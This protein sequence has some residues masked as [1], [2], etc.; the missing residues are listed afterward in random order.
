MTEKIGVIGAGAWGT[1]LAI[2]LADKGHDV[3]L[4]A[5]GDSEVPS[6]LVPTVPRALRGSE[7]DGDGSGWLLVT[8]SEVLKRAEDFDDNGRWSLQHF[9]AIV[10]RPAGDQLPDLRAVV[11]LAIGQLDEFLL[12]E[13]THEDV[14]LDLLVEDVGLDALMAEL[15]QKLFAERA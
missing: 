1:T 10:L 4:F 7:F 11:P 3:T 6:E 14:A 12:L 9:E 5:S 2:L 15:A 8:L 13:R